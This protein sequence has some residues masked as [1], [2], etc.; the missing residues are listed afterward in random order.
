MTCGA[1]QGQ[2]ACIDDGRETPAKQFCAVGITSTWPDWH[3]GIGEFR[4]NLVTG[5]CS[6]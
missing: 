6:Y 3:N 2:D 4:N 5:P 1:E